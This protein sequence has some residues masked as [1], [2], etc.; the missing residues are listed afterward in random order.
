MSDV[1]HLLVGQTLLVVDVDRGYLSACVRVHR[2]YAL[3]IPF[4]LLSLAA[5]SRPALEN[6]ANG[7]APTLTIKPTIR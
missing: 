3:A 7:T 6:G 2:Q 5:A 4:F 1:R